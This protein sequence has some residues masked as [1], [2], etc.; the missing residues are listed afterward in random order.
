MNEGFFYYVLIYFPVTNSRMLLVFTLI[1][2]NS[3]NYTPTW[4]TFR[5]NKHFMLINRLSYLSPG[6]IA[7]WSG[8]FYSLWDT[9]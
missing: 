2:S 5:K 8:R 1:C 3:V 6:Y 9:G 4:K 7:P